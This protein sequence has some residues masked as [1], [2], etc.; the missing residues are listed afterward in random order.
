MKIILKKIMNKMKDKLIMTQTDNLKIKPKKYINLAIL[1]SGKSYT[2]RVFKDVIRILNCPKYIC[3]KIKNNEAIAILPSDIKEPMSFRIPQG[4]FSNENV[5]FI[6]TSKSFVSG[7]LA[8]NNLN[9]ENTYRLLGY[10]SEKENAMFFNMNNI[11]VIKYNKK[12]KR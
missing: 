1:I 4:L 6:I 2:I 9:Y 5:Q 10:Y 12:N 8:G 3:L 7:I 11:Q